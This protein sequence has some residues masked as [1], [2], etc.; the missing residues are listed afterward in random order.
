MLASAPNTSGKW[1]ALLGLALIAC[2][3]RTADLGDGG[4]SSGGS[5]GGSGSGSG[6]FPYSGPSCTT[7]TVSDACWSC[8]QGSC[9][10]FA[11]C[12]TGSCASYFG[13]YCACP[14]NDASCEQGCQGSM[15][16]ACTSCVQNDE[17][18]VQGSCASACEAAMSGG[19]G[20]GGGSTG[21]GG[22]SG[23]TS[24]ISECSGSSQPC[25]NGQPLQSCMTLENGACTSAYFT[26][27]EQT[28]PCASCTDT[29]ACQQQA[30]A[31]CQ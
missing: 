19:G 17:S 14:L 28:F 27:G 10:A 24:S 18:C 6:G 30:N 8:L 31:A 29:T 7:A 21:G 9:P 3:G 12:I 23:G 13:C 2:G 11:G 4:T 25:P 1:M 15:S 26:V 16:P 20:S 22:S 5:G